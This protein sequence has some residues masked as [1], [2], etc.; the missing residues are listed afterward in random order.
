MT[1]VPDRGFAHGDM[2]HADDVFATALLTMAEEF[3]MT[4][5]P[6]KG[7]TH[8]GVF[9]AD[10]VFAT[11]LLTMLNPDIRV[12]R[13]PRVPD[14]F[15]GIVYDVGGGEFD[16]H[17]E[18]RCNRQN[19]VPYASFGLLWAR[20]GTLLLCEDDAAA[21]D[22]AFVQPIDDADN[23]GASCA[24]S[25]LVSDFNPF[26][27]SSPSDYDEAF[28][29]AVVWA[30]GVLRRRIGAMREARKAREYVLGRMVACDGRVLELEHLAPWKEAV[31]GSGY[32]YIIYPSVRGGYN[33]Q[34]VPDRLQDH[35]M[36]LPF[37]DVWRGASSE[38]LRGMTGIGGLNFCHATGFLCAAD[39]LEDALAAAR[40]SLQQG[41]YTAP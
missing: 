33:V 14:S 13:G 9:H 36:V 22:A 19:G 20:Y 26:P 8:D 12:D 10:D 37:P 39:T 15:E 6:D 28:R 18:S 23:G 34:A 29:E 31:V 32:V 21:F 11:A 27:P 24:V 35:S 5:V 38:E 30:L 1:D 2:F 4:D 16:H 41:G 17:G 3:C 40:L 25:Q 7:F